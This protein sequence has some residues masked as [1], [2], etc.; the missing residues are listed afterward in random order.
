[1]AYTVDDRLL[2]YQAEHFAKLE[3]GGRIWIGLGSWLFA[4][5]P[6]RALVQIQIARDVGAAGEALFS[7]D[8]IVSA[9]ALREAL[10]EEAQGER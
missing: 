1:M 8:S 5:R 4:K 9:P 3:H 10:L 6:E 2:R 7:Y